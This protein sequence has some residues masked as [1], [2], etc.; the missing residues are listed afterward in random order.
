M[1][2][3]KVILE[4]ITESGHY[5]SVELNGNEEGGSYTKIDWKSPD[6]RI[7]ELPVGNETLEIKIAS[8]HGWPEYKQEM[9][10]KC[11]WVLGV[12]VCT[13]VPVFYRRSCNKQVFVVVSYPGDVEQR[14][15]N[16]I[17]KCTTQAAA[18]SVAAAIAGGVAAALPVFS[19][20]FTECINSAASEYAS[21][22]SFKLDDKTECGDWT[23]Y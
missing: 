5:D 9:K 8:I 13:D 21:R 1:P 19:A 22:I 7:Q 2:E 3:T 10:L 12:R 6:V 23:P 11:K 18:L 20:A 4:F 15:K 16:E 17:K 14:I